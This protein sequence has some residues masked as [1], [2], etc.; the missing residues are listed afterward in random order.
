M[1]MTFTVVGKMR[2][3][4]EESNGAFNTYNGSLIYN[5]FVL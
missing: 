1:F 3:V 5:I 2:V 4:K